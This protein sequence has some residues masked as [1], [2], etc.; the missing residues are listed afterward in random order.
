[1]SGPN[2]LYAV[3][4]RSASSV[5]AVGDTGY[6]NRSLA[7]RWN[8]SA[9]RRV[10]VPDVGPLRAVAVE[11]GTTWLAGGSRVVRYTGGVG[12]VL[13]TPPSAATGYLSIGGLA[14]TADGLVAVG[15]V[16]I[17]YFEGY[18]STGWAARWAGSTWT[19]IP[20]G[21]PKAAVTAGSGG[22]W[23]VG[24]DVERI[25]GAGSLAAATPTG[26]RFHS[27][28]AS[29]PAGHVWSVGYAAQG[30]T[31][32]PSI[33]DSP[34]ATY[35]GLDVATFGSVSVTWVGPSTGSASATPFGRVLVG[36]LV[37]GTY[38]VVAS[39]PGCSPTVVTVVVAGMASPV[40]ARPAC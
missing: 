23:A 31:V 27:A 39:L 24:Q 38:T 28:V 17:P 7:L 15:T 26:F 16:Q 13:P 19:Q 22:V 11:A 10:A 21:A 18:I 36:G 9:W 37:P 5:W 25:V 20:I 6:P 14:A 30:G 3:A 29:S 32:V 12:T 34:S 4:A 8:G 2:H 1:V 33:L 40:T 35:G